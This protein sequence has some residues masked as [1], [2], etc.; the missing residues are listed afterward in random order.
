VGAPPE[1]F[2][3]R[4]RAI[5]SVALAYVTSVVAD[6]QRDARLVLISL[7][8]F[9]AAGEALG[10]G[11]LGIALG[12]SSVKGRRQPGDARILSVLGPEPD[13]S[14][15]HRPE[16]SGAERSVEPPPDGDDR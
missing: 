12:K 3:D 7:A 10:P 13:P 5:V 6:R 9:S 4:P 2:L 16:R 1:P 11:R 15:G 8:F 14:A